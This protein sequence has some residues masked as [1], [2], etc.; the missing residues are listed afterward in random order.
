MDPLLPHIDSPQDLKK[1]NVQQL[2]QLSEEIR[3]YIID[4]LSE[5]GG[6][7]APSLGV[8]ELTLVLH[9]L[10]SSPKDK[11]VWDVGHQSYAHKIITG[12]REAFKTIRQQGGIS[13]FPKPS[14][15]PYDAFGVGHASTAISAAFGMACARDLAGEKYNVIA[16][17]GDGAL[18]G[19]L[20][21]EGLNNAGASGKKIIVI[22]NDN[23]MS[24]S[25]NVGAIAKYLTNLISNPVY[26]R[27][28][29]E[30]WD[31]TGRFEKMG[32]RIRRAARK[33]E[34]TLKGFVVPGILFERLGFRYFGPIDGHN[35]NDL[36]NIL[37]EM[38]EFAGPML[39][40]VLTKKGRGYSPAEQ[41]APVFHGLGK[42]DKSTGQAIRASLVPTYTETFSQTMVDLAK[43][44]TKLVGITAAMSLGTG[45]KKFADL[46]PDR[47]FDVGIAEGHAVT[48]AGGMAMQGYR[49]VVA[50]Y[51]SFLQRSYDHVIHDLALQRLPVI[52]AIDRAG[53][54]GDDGPTHH[55]VFDLAFLRTIPNLVIMAPKDEE[56]L[57]HMLNTAAAYTEGPVAVRY[58]R[59]HG[60]GVVLSDEYKL[61]P[62]GK[63]E[64]VREGKEIAILAAGPTVYRAIAAAELLEQSLGLST[65]V[66]N[67]RFIKPVDHAM[68]QDVASRFKL[69]ITME[70][71]IIKGGFGSEVAEFLVDEKHLGVELIRCGLPDAFISQGDRNYLLD[72]AGLSPEAILKAVESS[73]AFRSLK[74]TSTLKGLFRL[75]RKKKSA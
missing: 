42:F 44:N 34:A 71:G 14:E 30:I 18:T 68:L 23:T 58:P 37:G 52:L 2:L 69:I 66:V 16:V 25:P 50:I 67:A 60:E 29:S 1:L 59:G 61:L 47:F 70:E 53:L 9:K 62:I 40:H 49:P 31:F 28:K 45:L 22:L 64:W 54:V 5:T 51:S 32:P 17:V 33:M 63:S 19:G 10:F 41:N 57:R 24:I 38:R 48:F 27:I 7:L 6:H 56:E 74:R 73:H 8:V 3:A 43:T 55:G 15:S 35:M 11:I 39:L 12:R 13:G 36:I 21:F 65:A 26:N 20:A 72:E 46:Y 4:T 75:N